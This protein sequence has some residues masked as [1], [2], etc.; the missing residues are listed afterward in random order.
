[1]KLDVGMVKFL[2]RDDF[3][4]LVAVEQGMKNHE[5]V[6]CDLIASISG[7]PLSQ[8]F[9][10]LGNVHKHK[11]VFHSRQK[12]DGYRLTYLG[13]DYLALRALVNRGVI[14][15]IGRRIG[16]GKESDVYEVTN[17][18]GRSMALKL[19][20]LGRVS[21]R[22]IKQKRDYLG[23]RKS[24]SWLYMSRLAATR[25]FAY[26][27]AL[28]ARAFPV[29]EP[30]D[31]NRH[32]V[33]M[34]MAAG[35]PLTNIRE[36]GRPRVI[37]DKLMRLILRLAEYGLVHGDFNE[38]NLLIDDDGG[39]TLIDF[40]QMISTSHANAVEQFDRDVQCVR[41][42]FIKKFKYTC[43]AVPRLQADSEKHVALDVE[44]NASGCDPND[45]EFTEYLG[46]IREGDNEDD[47]SD[48]DDEGNDTQSV[49]VETSNNE[50]ID[51]AADALQGCTVKG[52]VGEDDEESRT[53]SE[54]SSCDDV[55]GGQEDC[56]PASSTAGA[57]MDANA[58]R[59]RVRQRRAKMTQ[60]RSNRMAKATR[61]RKVQ[62]RQAIR[63][64]VAR[65][66][67]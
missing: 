14:S 8:A 53:D 27:K 60:K 24:A 17:D 41:T 23:K 4:I 16:V 10:C 49:G 64:T 48:D 21:F 43:D 42:F 65:Q 57:T 20:R 11:L 45:L 2:T 39:I 40:P 37:I 34:S 13:Y 54:A 19:H 29:P 22:A 61:H 67:A 50:D 62:S 32:C 18:E 12:C 6:P 58:I 55:D 66:A 44:L 7:L 9:R 25:E 31:C 30:V 5:L 59:D 28:H 51:T 46:E 35:C 26:M 63:R 52:D 3:R 15:A 47:A 38:F 1:M 56:E 33:V 36:L